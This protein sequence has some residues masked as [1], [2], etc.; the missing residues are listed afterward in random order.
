[1]ANDSIDKNADSV[2]VTAI[3]VELGLG[4]FAIGLGWL[5]GVDV[6]QWIPKFD[7][8]S[9]W[10]LFSG[11]ALGVVAAL[12]MLALISLI[13]RLNWE[14]IRALKALEDMPAI[15]SLLALTRGELIAISVAAGVG[16][17]LLLRGWL[18]GWVTGPLGDATPWAIAAGLVASSIA[19]GL[20]H[21]ITPAYAVIA[22]IIGLY[23]GGLVI[24]TENLIVAM[25][26]HGFYDTVHLLLAKRERARQ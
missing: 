17:E 11:A 16:E 12:P 9:A 20:M 13:E 21:P 5:T 6:R 2:F 25:V 14:P 8:G 26:A 1:M 23:L 10:P 19:F 24:W 7:A 15:S 4:V 22:A 3:A 18:M